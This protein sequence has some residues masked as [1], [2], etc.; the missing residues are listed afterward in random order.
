M[1]YLLEINA[2]YEWLETNPLQRSE[3]ALW[4]ALMHINN[5][6]H[7]QK[8]FMVP[9]STL[10]L[11]AGLRRADLFKA[12]KRLVEV[13]LIEYTAGCTGHSQ[14]A[15]YTLKPFFNT[16]G[17]PI[18]HYSAVVAEAPKVETPKAETPEAEPPEAEPPEAD[19]QIDAN[20][21]G[22]NEVFDDLEN[23]EVPC[24]PVLPI[25]PLAAAESMELEDAD[26]IPNN[27]VYRTQ[28]I[29]ESDPLFDQNRNNKGPKVDPI[30]KQKENKQNFL[31][32][33]NGSL[34]SGDDERQDQKN[35]FG[36]LE[37]A[38]NQTLS[39][40]KIGRQHPERDVMNLY[41]RICVDLPRATSLPPRRKG[42]ISARLREYGYDTV[43]KMLL[44]AAK[45]DFLS[46]GYKSKW[47]ANIDW[48][49]RPN[50]FVKVLEGHYAF[51]LP[52]KSNHKNF[53]GK[54]SPLEVLE[55]TYNGIMNHQDE[56]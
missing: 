23:L 6:S 24:D 22:D 55:E 52:A 10:Q 44:Q 3:I 39:G 25:I 49:F 16:M 32:E 36:D 9:V 42:F 43:H 21:Y 5:K 50:N 1:N 20:G 15:S 40:K 29:A 37:E 48:L 34:S 26:E 51:M 18:N 31:E 47:T 19:E 11:K 2:F 45:S 53:V 28:I 41:N 27:Q 13:G 12:R 7:W 14:A 17:E 33:P 35:L 54:P 8:S 30:S 56:Y 46:R 38:R 4:S